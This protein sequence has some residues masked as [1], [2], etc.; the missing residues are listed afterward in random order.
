MYRSDIDGLDLD[1]LSVSE[2][3]DRQHLLVS[4][5]SKTSDTGELLTMLLTESVDCLYRANMRKEGLE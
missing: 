1:A 3:L 4:I 5:A 2:L